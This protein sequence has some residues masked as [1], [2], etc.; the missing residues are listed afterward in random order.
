MYCRFEK[1]PAANRPQ[2]STAA[3]KECSPMHYPNLRVLLQLA[4]TLAMTSCECESS[5]STRP[6]RHTNM[7]G[8]MSHSHSATF[9]AMSPSTSTWLLTYLPSSTRD[10]WNWSPSSS[11][12]CHSNVLLLD[13]FVI[14]P[15]RWWLTT[16]TTDCSL[17]TLNWS[18][19]LF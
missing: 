9:T 4:C 11:W 5:A 12:R 14:F 15:V 1:R 3:M 2:T 7:R 13:I 8:S 10:T 17:I 6:W 18:L 16:V 19:L